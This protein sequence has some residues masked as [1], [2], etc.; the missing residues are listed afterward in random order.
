MDLQSKVR[1]LLD[2]ILVENG[3]VGFFTCA[4][5]D[6]AWVAML[7]KPTEDGKIWLFPECFH[8]IIKSQLPDG[9]WPSYAADVDGILNTAASLLALKTHLLNPYQIT[10]YPP[11][12][13]NRRVSSAAEWLGSIL[14]TWDV[15]KAVHVGFEILVPAILTRLEEQGLY[16]A[17]PGRESLMKLN[18]LKLSHFDIAFLYSPIQT[19]ALHSLEAFVGKLNYDKVRH[20]KR[21]GAYMA[22]PSSTAACLMYSSSWDD[23]SEEYLKWTLAVG[24]GRGSGGVP[25]AFPST[26]F[27]ITW[28]RN[29]LF[30]LPQ[31]NMSYPSNPAFAA[32][33]DNSFRRGFYG[34]G[35]RQDSG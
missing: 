17:F 26:F 24:V 8:Y 20:H 14:H 18:Q 21:F 22:S 23:E 6:T 29:F 25:S 12:E 34:R 10:E 7:A 2:L 4:I 11:E 1:D 33:F 15:N 35:Y 32:G 5:Y 9:G 19:T 28:V 30:W 16:F 13:L 3:D 27:D 31:M